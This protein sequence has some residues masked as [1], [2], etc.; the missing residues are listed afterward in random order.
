M[1]KKMKKNLYIL[2]A[3]L[4]SM[5]V[6]SCYKIFSV[7]APETVQQ[8][9]EFTVT[10]TVV[11]DGDQYQ[12]YIK[13][14]SVA[15]IRVPEGW[16]VSAPSK[17]HKGIA[18][19]WVYYEDGTQ[20]KREFPMIINERLSGFYNEACPKNGYQWT[21][22]QTRAM[23]PKFISACWRNGCDSI[24]VS[25]KVKVP[26]DFAPGTYTIDLI[27]GDI[28]NEAGADA[29]SNAAQLKEKDSRAFHVGTFNNAKIDKADTRFSRQITVA[30]SES[31]SISRAAVVNPE[32]WS[33][34][35]SVSGQRLTTPRKGVNIINGKAHVVK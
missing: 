26:A 11:D 21:A 19:D 17:C 10:M 24:Q 20:A 13:D 22:L 7:I 28:E 9:D 5:S 14:W 31:S 3:L 30:A 32:E 8:G 33:T 6:S 18:E 34:I 15:G 23:V 35:Y 16:T 12:K 25:F 2:M 1:S 4:L 29:Y 27:G